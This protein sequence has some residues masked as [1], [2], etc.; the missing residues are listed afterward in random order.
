MTTISSPTQFSMPT[1]KLDNLEGGAVVTGRDT[2]TL[3]TPAAAPQVSIRDAVEITVPR[4]QDKPLLKRPEQ[5]TVNPSLLFDAK[6][7]NKAEL[8]ET[9]KVIGGFSSAYANLQAHIAV[10]A[11]KV[12][13]AVREVIAEENSKLE[14]MFPT[15]ANLDESEIKQLS[16]GVN[17]ML[18]ASAIKDV[19]VAQA[20]SED[21]KPGIQSFD[22]I[23]DSQFIGIMSSDILMELRNLLSQIKSIINTTDRQLQ[24]DFLKLKAQM[25][26]S[27]ADTTIKEGEK[28][29]LGA[30]LGFAVSMGV[31]LAGA[32][33]QTKQLVKQTKAINMH[34]VARNQHT[35]SAQDSIELSRASTIKTTN[36]ALNQQNDLASLRHQDAGRR[37]QL[38]ADEHQTKLD[39]ITNQTQKKSSIIESVTRLSDNAGQLVTS[40]VQMDVKAL[41]AQKMVLQDIGD[42]ARS[43]ANDKEKQID[44]VLD[45][46]K[47]VFDI[48]KDVIEGQIR[49]FQAVATRG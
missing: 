5:A 45:L 23:K 2:Q 3:S 19:Q 17:L 44:T 34:G 8:E 22:A 31:T 49:T 15:I 1:Q 24:A 46:M 25:V 33:L 9:S 11:T 16:Q 18:A 39:K 4:S 35:S 40:A 36:K 32:A 12:E 37:S 41:E 6:N 13:N 21:V 27:A 26:Q 42:T 38:K 48:L 43:I 7:M 14:K 10:T 29:F 20:N 28:A 47:K 30:V